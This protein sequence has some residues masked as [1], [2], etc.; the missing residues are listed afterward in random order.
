MTTNSPFRLLPVAVALAAS[1][2]LF[3]LQMSKNWRAREKV[4]ILEAKGKTQLLINLVFNGF[5]SLN[6]QLGNQNHGFMKSENKS[7]F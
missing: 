7:T 4:A 3:M 1:R 2:L 5:A 6:M